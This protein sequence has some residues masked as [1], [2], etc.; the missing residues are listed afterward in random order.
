MLYLIYQGHTQTGEPLQV[1]LN[2]LSTSHPHR[3]N[4]SFPEP[5]PFITRAGQAVHHR[6]IHD[7]E[8]S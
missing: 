2:Q 6:N 4:E 8:D 3:A 5:M 7:G 1:T